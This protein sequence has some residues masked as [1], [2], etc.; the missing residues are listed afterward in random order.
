MTQHF[1]P[2]LPQH[3]FLRG[4]LKDTGGIL[5]PIVTVQ[6]VLRLVAGHTAS[7]GGFIPL[8][9]SQFF[10]HFIGNF[11]IFILGVPRVKVF[12]IDGSHFMYL[13]SDFCNWAN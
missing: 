4:R 5:D 12:E 10:C 1:Q 8:V 2:F 7:I 11:R 13:R 6:G 9:G 3:Q